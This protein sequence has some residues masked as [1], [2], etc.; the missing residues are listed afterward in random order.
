M[1][2]LFF[3]YDNMVVFLE[4]FS[5]ANLPIPISPQTV[6]PSFDLGFSIFVSVPA[7]SHFFIMSSSVIPCPL[8]SITIL[9]F[10]FPI[11]SNVMKTFF[12]SASLA[13]LT[14]SKM[15]DASLEMD[16]LPK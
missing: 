16:W 6:L 1:F 4:S 9:A 3:G 12:A 10:F 15:A 11:F 2:F 13:F 14:S 5:H 7:T 8:S